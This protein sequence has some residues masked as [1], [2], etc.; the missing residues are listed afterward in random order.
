[1][2]IHRKRFAFTSVCGMVFW[3]VESSNSLLVDTPAGVTC[4]TCRKLGGA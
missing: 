1:M 3:P 2:K 4:K